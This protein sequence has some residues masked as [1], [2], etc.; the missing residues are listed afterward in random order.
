MA[1]GSTETKPRELCQAVAE[2][3]QQCAESPLLCNRGLGALAVT[4]LPIPIARRPTATACASGSTHLDG[5][6]R[7]SV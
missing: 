7:V 2:H 3:F 4:V 5:A 1:M 6:G